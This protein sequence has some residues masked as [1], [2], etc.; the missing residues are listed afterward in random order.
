MNSEVTLLEQIIES[1]QALIDG[2]SKLVNEKLAEIEGCK[3]TIEQMKADRAN[4]LE[5]MAVKNLDRM[6]FSD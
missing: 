1:Q 4:E 6:V 3:K 2:L 5:V